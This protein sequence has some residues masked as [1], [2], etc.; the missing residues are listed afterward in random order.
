MVQV[1]I[2]FPGD[3]TFFLQEEDAGFL[4]S[5]GAVGLRCKL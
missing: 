2:Q 5:I 1:I 4:V 3:G